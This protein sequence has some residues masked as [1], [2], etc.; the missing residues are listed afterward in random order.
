MKRYFPI[1]ASA[2]LALF[3]LGSGQRKATHL[4]S[5]HVQADTKTTPAN[6]MFE[7]P[8]GSGY[9]YEK[10]PTIH[11]K[12]ILSFSPFD[13]DDGGWG[14]VFN[15]N[16]GGQAA[17]QA[18]AAANQGR[19]LCAVVRATPR[20]ITKLDGYNNDGRIVI[21]EKLTPEDMAELEKKYTQVH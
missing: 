3:C 2:I 13:G 12:Q 21:W 8:P 5:F 7:W 11:Q 1:L 10:T 15:L 16:T 17:L 18:A 14:A 19:Y 6:R 4:I 20:A 9:F